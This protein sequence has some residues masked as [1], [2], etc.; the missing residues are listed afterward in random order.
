MV[1]RRR[2]TSFTLELLSLAWTLLQLICVTFSGYIML[3][4]AMDQELINDLKKIIW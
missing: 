2:K 1:I 4:I 3:R